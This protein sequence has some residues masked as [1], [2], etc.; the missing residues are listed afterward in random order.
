MTA[1]ALLGP[2]RLRPTVVDTVAELAPSGTVAAVTA[3]WQE[4]EREVE[5][6]ATHLDRE[7]VN[8]ELYGRAESV[9]AAD[10]ELF[11]AL[12]IRQDRLQRLQQLYRLRLDHAL[13]GVWELEGLEGADPLLEDQ[14]G[15]AL[16]ALRRLDRAH[17]ER[18]RHLHGEFE[19]RWRPGERSVV[20]EHRAELSEIL[21]GS[22]LLTIAGGHVA[23]LLNRLRLF[24]ILGLAPQLPVVAW[25]GGAMVL[26]ETVV[27]FHDSPPQGAGNAEVFEAGLGCY[28]ELLALPHA[29]RR[30]RL[31]DR[32]RVGI[33][34]RR[35]GPA[36]CV[37]LDEGD[38]VTWSGGEWRSERGVR[39]LGE[40]GG[41]RRG[42]FSGEKRA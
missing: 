41:V 24:G 33:L 29:S 36:R 3:G 13:A 6:L 23:V 18:I 14:R 26:G 40:D 7:V 12:R 16:E 31:D 25:S 11:G 8:L 42:T 30:L 1:I 27:L 21:G 2:Q 32:R 39:R 37:A 4:R 19:V 22:S 5:E 38:E 15:A 9:A 20:A 17:L 28:P 35:F 10:P 34:A